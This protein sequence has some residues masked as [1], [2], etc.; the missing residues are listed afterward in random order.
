MVLALHAIRGHGSCHLR[1]SLLPCSVLRYPDSRIRH[2]L[3]AEES[4]EG[5]SVW[6]VW[7]FVRHYYWI[8]HL[9]HA[10]LLGYGRTKSGLQIHEVVREVESNGLNG[11]YDDNLD[12]VR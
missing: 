11:R 12:L 3:D 10:N 9:L 2:R 7:D 8:V 1:P 6:H 4:E 5:Y